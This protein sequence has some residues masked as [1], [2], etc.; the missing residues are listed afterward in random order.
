MRVQYISMLAIAAMTF[1]ACNDDDEDDNTPGNQLTI[2]SE[3]IA[4]D[5]EANVA[6]ESMV[7]DELSALASAAGDAES[8]AGGSTTIEPLDYPSTLSSVTLPS[9]RSLI[10][11]WTVELVNAANSPTPFQIPLLDANGP[12]PGEEGGLLGTRL[13]D[14]YGL[15]L[16]QTIEKGSFG[17]ALYNHAVAVANGE[18]IAADVDRL[19]EIFGSEPTFNP[20]LATAAAKYAKRRS[21]QTT[22][23]GFLY[24]MRDNAITVK[25][26]VEAGSE[27]N[28]TRD[29]ALQEYLLNWE[30]SNFA[31]VI[32]YCN[33]AKTG[34]QSANSIQDETERRAA[35]GD[36][37]HAYGEGVGFAHGF[38]GLDNKLITDAEIDQILTNLLAP[39]GQTPE[40]YR[41]LNEATLLTN[42]DQ[43]IDDIQA[44]YG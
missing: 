44:I 36:A 37:I 23:T 40:T 16:K 13:L 15:E 42:F 24:D 3:Y 9:Y 41:F 25:A 26:A 31:T 34:I 11:N 28:A 18:L 5:Y 29:E 39:D 22:Q 1:T 17:A 7:I 6:T 19:V 2:P 8:N 21:N 38:K 10:E 27:F 4:P 30:K 14:E 32:F 20:E 33:S 43:I 35:L 12:A